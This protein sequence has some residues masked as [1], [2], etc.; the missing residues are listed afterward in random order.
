MSDYEKLKT[1][2]DE[3]DSL[4]L[5]RVKSSDPRFETWQTKVERLL[6]KVYGES[7]E[8]RINF[9]HTVFSP[10]VYT[11][12][13]TDVDYIE[14]CADGLKSTK[15][16]LSVYLEEMADNSEEHS[17]PANFEDKASDFSNVFIV[18]GNVAGLKEA[19]ARLVERQN[20]KAIILNEQANGSRALIEKLEGYSDV[21]GAICLFTP[22]DE[23]KEKGAL[24]LSAR[25]RQNVVFEAGYF[26][27]KLGRNKTII[28]SNGDVELPSDMQ[29]I[30][31]TNNEEWRYK[32]LKE[33][34][35]MG[36][37]I[38]FEQLG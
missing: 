12:Y 4:I 25:A 15:S 19:V 24:E 29:G 38:D 16:V 33:L 36:Y 31:Y 26:M 10:I 22:D 2:Y 9:L 8:E 23:G 18:E 27:G 34:K 32:T 3:I 7:S 37:A 6:K 14:A 20:I 35:A 28:L 5:S 1:L 11:S 30:V 13:T 21:G 17:V